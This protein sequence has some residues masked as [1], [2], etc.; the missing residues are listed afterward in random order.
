VLEDCGAEVAPASSVA[1]A[2]KLVEK[3]D[4][5]VVVSDVGMPDQDGYEFIRLVRA[6]RSPSQLPAAALTAF[7]RAEDR[8]RALL[9]GFQTHV[10]KPVDPDELVA[11]VASLAGKTETA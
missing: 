5:D 7:A 8:R 6:Q 1:E 4:P 11:V 3:F 10:V 9:A 2:L